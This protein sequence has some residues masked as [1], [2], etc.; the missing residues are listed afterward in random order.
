MR[1]PFCNEHALNQY[2][3]QWSGIY[4]RQPLSF[5]S[6]MRTKAQSPKSFAVSHLYANLSFRNE[7]LYLF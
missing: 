2:L 5:V 1:G 6:P 4:F 7:V 3:H